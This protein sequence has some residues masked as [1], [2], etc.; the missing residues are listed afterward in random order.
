MYIID[1]LF[2]LNMSD[3]DEVKIENL[4]FWSEESFGLRDTSG[5]LNHTIP[6]IL[7]ASN[8]RFECREEFELE[9]LFFFTL[10]FTLFYFGGNE[11]CPLFDTKLP[12]GGNF[13]VQNSLR[14]RVSQHFPGKLEMI[15]IF[16]FFV[17][18]SFSLWPNWRGHLQC[19]NIVWW[20]KCSPRRPREEEF[21]QN[22]CYV[23]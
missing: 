15:I 6:S 17:F 19:T 18:H 3:T 21:M 16:L 5:P 22:S 13:R 14:G 4:A 23:C 8:E 10:H 9:I 2:I 12:V 20:I 7:C 11:M 1:D